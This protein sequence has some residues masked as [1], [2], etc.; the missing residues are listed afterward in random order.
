[1]GYLYGWIK[2]DSNGLCNM[3]IGNL[4]FIG[5]PESIGK[6]AGMNEV[7]CI[8]LQADYVSR[9]NIAHK[10][11]IHDIYGDHVNC[12]IMVRGNPHLSDT[13]TF[14]G[15]QRK[16]YGV[17]ILDISFTNIINYGIK[18]CGA[19]SK[20]KNKNVRGMNGNPDSMGF[21]T[22]LTKQTFIIQTPIQ[23]VRLVV[24]MFPFGLLCALISRGRISRF[25]DQGLVFP[26]DN[27]WILIIILTIALFDMGI[28]LT[29]PEVRCLY[30]A[31]IA[32]LGMLHKDILRRARIRTLYI[33]H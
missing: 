9:T 32:T 26:I 10:I 33:R 5:T 28:V 1:M 11:Y 4:R 16:S 30:K 17:R 18:L 23:K 3:E 29:M 25:T 12:G 22:L 2:G 27:R 15:D 7:A 19:T 31:R 13:T 21:I 6:S 24:P 14:Y 8:L 20:N